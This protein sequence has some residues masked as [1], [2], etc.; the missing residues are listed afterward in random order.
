MYGITDLKKD[1]VFQMDGKPYKV[2]EYN[3]KQ[4]GRGGSIVNVRIKNLLDGAVT[5]KTFKGQDKIEPAEIDIKKVQYLYSDDSSCHFM[6]E[7]T[8]EQ[9]EVGK[10]ILGDSFK[11][12]KESDTV[13]AHLFEGVVINVELPIKIPLEVTSTPDVVRGDTQSTV[14]KEATLETG[15]IVQVPIFIKQGDVIIVDTRDGSYVER[16]KD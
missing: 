11:F 7:T 4:V 3:Q 8:Y 6:D 1:T 10:D 13:K 12:M 14:L 16:K 2:V 9:L 5:Q 15:A